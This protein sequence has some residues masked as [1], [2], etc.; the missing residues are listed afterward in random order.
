MP[1]FDPS[2]QWVKAF[3]LEEKQRVVPGAWCFD[4]VIRVVPFD[5]ISFSLAD[6]WPL[7]R[8]LGL[9]ENPQHLFVGDR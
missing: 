4:D 9:E 1:A 3:E 6:L 8:P 7:D 5:G 2:L